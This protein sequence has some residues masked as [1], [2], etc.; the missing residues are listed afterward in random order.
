M[1]MAEDD[2]DSD[3]D[4]LYIDE[5]LE[6]PSPKTGS[7]NQPQVPASTATTGT[8]NLPDLDV[9][10]L[11]LLRNKEILK[12]IPL[13]PKETPKQTPK[14]ACRDFSRKP[15][16]ASDLL[17]SALYHH[18]TTDNPPHNKESTGLP[19]GVTAEDNRNLRHLLDEPRRPPT[20]PYA[21]PAA[22]RGVFPQIETFTAPQAQ[23]SPI[24]P[25]NI[26]GYVQ[27]ASR[28]QPN[29]NVYVQNDPSNQSNTNVYIQHGQQIVANQMSI[30]PSNLANTTSVIVPH[31]GSPT[32]VTVT[33]R[34]PTERPVNHIPL[35]IN[36]YPV[37]NGAA[38]VNQEAQG[39]QIY[40]HAETRR[41]YYGQTPMLYQGATPYKT[42][43]QTCPCR[44][45]AKPHSPS[46]PVAG[47]G[48][49]TSMPLN[50]GY[51]FISPSS[52][53]QQQPI[54][55]TFNPHGSNQ[56]QPA[57]Q[58][59]VMNPQSLNAF[60]PQITSRP[61]AN[62]QHQPTHYLNPQP[63]LSSL[64][65]MTLSMASEHQSMTSQNLM[66]TSIQPSTGRGRDPINMS[67]STLHHQAMNVSVNPQSHSSESP[68]CYSCAMG[69]QC[70]KNAM[71][72]Y[73]NVQPSVPVPNP[74]TSAWNGYRQDNSIPSLLPQN[75]GYNNEQN[76]R[77]AYLASLRSQELIQNA[78]RDILGPPGPVVVNKK[79]SAPAKPR[80]KPVRKRY[81]VIP[82]S[83]AT[84]IF[85]EAINN[86]V[87][88]SNMSSCSITVPNWTKF[89]TEDTAPKQPTPKHTKAKV[90]NVTKSQVNIEHV[91]DL[92]T[93]I[94]QST[95]NVAFKQSVNEQ[96]SLT[97]TSNMNTI[98][99]I[100]DSSI[101]EHQSKSMDVNDNNN[102]TLTN[103]MKS[104]TQQDTSSNDTDNQSKIPLIMDMPDLSMEINVEP[105][106][107]P[108]VNQITTNAITKNV[109]S[110]TLLQEAS[111]VIDLETALALLD[112]ETDETTTNVT[113]NS[114]ALSTS[115]NSYELVSTTSVTTATTSHNI[116][117]NDVII[118]TDAPNSEIHTNRT[119]NTQQIIEQNT[120]TVSIVNQIITNPNISLPETK[121]LLDIL[122]NVQQYNIKESRMEQSCSE[123]E[124]IDDV[125]DAT[126]T[127]GIEEDDGK[128]TNDGT[129]DR[130]KTAR[131]HLARWSAMI[132]HNNETKLADNNTKTNNCNVY[133][134]DVKTGHQGEYI[135]QLEIPSSDG[136][137]AK[138]E[139]FSIN[140]SVNKT[141]DDK[142][143]DD[144]NVL[145]QIES[146]IDNQDINDTVESNDTKN[147]ESETSV[148]ELV[149]FKFQINFFRL[150]QER[151]T[152]NNH[153][154][155]AQ[156][157]HAAIRDL[158][159]ISDQDDATAD[160]KYECH[161]CHNITTYS[162]R[163]L[164]Y[165]GINYLSSLINGANKCQLCLIF[166][167]KYIE[168]LMKY[169]Q[170]ET[171]GKNLNTSTTSRK[172]ATG[173]S[174]INDQPSDMTTDL[175]NECKTHSETAHQNEK[176]DNTDKQKTDCTVTEQQSETT[177]NVS[178]SSS[179]KQVEISEISL[180]VNISLHRLKKST[181]EA[182]TRCQKSKS[183]DKKSNR[184]ETS[185]IADRDRHSKGNNNA[186]NPEIESVEGSLPTK[187]SAT[188]V[189]DNS[190]IGASMTTSTSENET[191]SCTKKLNK[192]AKNDSTNILENK[193]Q[194]R[195]A[196]KRKSSSTE[197]DFSTNPNSQSS[198]SN[199]NDVDLES[200]P[201]QKKT[202]SYETPSDSQT[203]NKTIV[204]KNK[205]DD[206][207]KHKTESKKR[208]RVTA[209]IVPTT[210]SDI[211]K[212]DTN[213]S[214]NVDN[215]NKD[216]HLEK[217]NKICNKTATITSVDAHKRKTITDNK[218]SKKR[219]STSGEVA[220]SKTPELENKNT[221]V[222]ENND[223]NKNTK[224]NANSNEQQN[225]C[226][227]KERPQ[228][229]TKNTTTEDKE[230]S[231]RN[232]AAKNKTTKHTNATKNI[233]L[234]TASKNDSPQRRKSN[235]KKISS[236]KQPCNS[237]I[238]E[239]SNNNKDS[240]QVRKSIDSETTTNKDTE[241]RND[242]DSL[243]N[244]NKDNEHN[245]ATT[246]KARESTNT[247]ISSKKQT[248]ISNNATNSETITDNHGEIQKIP[249]LILKLFGDRVEKKAS[250]NHEKAS[251]KSKEKTNAIQKNNVPKVEIPGKKVDKSKNDK[252]D[253]D[254]ILKITD[255]FICSTCYVR[256]KCFTALEK[257]LTDDHEIVKVDP[258]DYTH[259][260]M[261]TCPFCNIEVIEKDFN[262]HVKARHA[263]KHAKK[264]NKC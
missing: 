77:A 81:N 133:R 12:N 118:R 4:C 119:V 263:D 111:D 195:C 18:L 227:N 41:E 217:Q 235:D 25:P 179:F 26:N 153:E 203:I 91:I 152:E 255:K 19:N 88:V 243:A 6:G 156:K 112:A 160:I 162:P 206:N 218:P 142:S 182:L 65:Q 61:V 252:K 232:N 94:T 163:Q 124:K 260:K 10:F 123:N 130:L 229:T 97:T 186:N 115:I 180:V 70:A 135:A 83:S 231:N 86:D 45:G 64:H 105:P 101:V 253:I 204:S 128:T 238:N 208:K 167:R 76:S 155:Y 92:T 53:P 114:K 161:E 33:L 113:Q 187:R 42:C 192:S 174:E 82:S 28:T 21:L 200:R 197:T 29:I 68:P 173:N 89:G 14:I 226:K 106:I 207:K 60:N 138:Q 31:P 7:T 85:N 198:L 52:R 71:P 129:F 178:S 30:V 63:H 183:D 249:S 172:E 144:I 44:R 67:P 40:N 213:T 131:Q 117:S 225:N 222:S 264:L 108:S 23:N 212:K 87:Y 56:V 199:S 78:T 262:K 38:P 230:I 157:L 9:D 120:V 11:P 176:D 166:R 137:T 62:L 224:N 196:N 221:N 169:I 241:K 150:V 104:S 159:R 175:V 181:V 240:N 233:R 164:Y 3:N 247:D 54:N 190:N 256:Y 154:V 210:F 170:L 43:D 151:L 149:F 246:C 201:K 254:S 126:Y 116:E 158:I 177:A 100:Q 141:T 80:A 145:P 148:D 136:S 74:Q 1:V 103:L 194:E 72:S 73:L 5:G 168:V 125:V 165:N 96:T 110:E 99:L 237:E 211:N 257:H 2:D 188:T 189:H 193:N 90:S 37:Q 75:P 261:V 234:E 34:Q 147:E 171:S 51:E 239:G 127:K 122:N 59:Q 20:I 8:R 219:K 236:S 16:D 214:N 209:E 258:S 95:V 248:L 251:N 228:E 132:D 13:I 121:T 98:N 35:T 55:S 242:Q 220:P 109:Q 107:Q 202:M 215:Q 143:A 250:Q 39:R 93:D 140:S 22:H 102:E 185:K 79:T 36:G 48:V 205:D 245:I 139:T 84:I 66:N 24:T 146:K 184:G 47:R 17:D 46:N 32:G 244:K 49:V 134:I 50:P 58:S 15:F 57:P 259:V 27:N 191:E 216:E 223:K 69:K